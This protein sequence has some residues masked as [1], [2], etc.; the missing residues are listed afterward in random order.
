MLPHTYYPVSS[1]VAS[2]SRRSLA[3]CFNW[4]IRRSCFQA[5][6]CPDIQSRGLHSTIPRQTFHPAWTE[7]R[8]KMPYIEALTK[9]REEK[10]AGLTTGASDK[11]RTGGP[12]QAS[13]MTPKRMKDS[14]YRS[15]SIL[16]T[17]FVYFSCLN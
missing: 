10:G 15:V 5:T 7:A 11:A 13:N 1:L 2:V 9:S 16:Y 12:V 3:S 8:V 6:S 14:Y 17:P 4:G